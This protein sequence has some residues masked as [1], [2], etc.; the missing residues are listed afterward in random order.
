MDAVSTFESVL[1][2]AAASWSAGYR[3]APALMLGLLALIAVPLTAFLASVARWWTRRRA[4]AP[5]RDG[6]VPDVPAPHNRQA[7]LE[8]LDERGRRVALQHDMVRIGRDH[9]NDIR[10]PSKRVHRYHAAIHREDFGTYRITD[11]AGAGGNG[12]SVNGALCAEAELKDGDLIE[13]GPGRMRF[14]A[15]L[16]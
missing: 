9:D 16:V 5:I 1:N 6:A 12:V 2:F 10:I 7:F 4:S 11:L 15:G 3:A 13:L 8:L 14:H